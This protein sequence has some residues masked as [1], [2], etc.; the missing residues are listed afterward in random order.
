[1]FLPR[2]KTRMIHMIQLA[3][4]FVRIACMQTKYD[5]GC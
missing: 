5:G 2:R 4:F 3:M 1:M